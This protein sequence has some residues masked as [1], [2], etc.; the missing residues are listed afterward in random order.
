MAPDNLSTKTPALC[1]VDTEPVSVI[2]LKYST[3]IGSGFMGFRLSRFSNTQILPRYS[4]KI[5]IF[6]AL[7]NIPTLK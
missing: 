2:R 4:V 7:S 3:R 5:T 1:L 6:E